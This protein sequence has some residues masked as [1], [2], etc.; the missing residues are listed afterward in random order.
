MKWFGRRDDDLQEEIREHIA[1]GTRENM[2]RGMP[3]EEARRAA[4]RTFGNV[5]VTR[6]RVREARPLHWLETLWQ[7]ARYGSRQIRRRPMLAAVVVATMAFGVGLNTGIFTL[8]N[9]ELLRSGVE[10]PDSFVRVH[11]VYTGDVPLGNPRSG[12]VSREDYLACREATQTI[13]D[14][15][16][17]HSRGG[18]LDHDD[19]VRV[20]ALE[21]SCNY[22]AVYGA[23]QLVL[24][25]LFL[26]E[27]CASRGPQE[28]TVLSEGLWRDRYAAAPNIVGRVVQFDRGP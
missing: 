8:I 27:E 1:M 14:L 6:E 19:T 26:E 11:P 5:G 15:A 9:A 2:E 18:I 25:R 22:F 20:P 24:G 13:R 7:D 17:W 3:P 12:R 4:Q 10:D 16:A 23:R 21:V 28:V